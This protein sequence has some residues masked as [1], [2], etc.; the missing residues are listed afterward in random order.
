MFRTDPPIKK[1][2]DGM[3]A[4]MDE[5]L[6]MVNNPDMVRFAMLSCYVGTKTQYKTVIKE[7]LSLGSH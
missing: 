4:P 1:N 2:D 5:M 3:A 7:L 6:F